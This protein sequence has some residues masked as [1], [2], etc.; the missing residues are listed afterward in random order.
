MLCNQI[1]STGSASFGLTPFGYAA[2]PDASMTPFG[3]AATPDAMKIRKE[4]LNTAHISSS[5]QDSKLK[6]SIKVDPLFYL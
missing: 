1:E 3:Y 2:T 4:A 6:M 5:C